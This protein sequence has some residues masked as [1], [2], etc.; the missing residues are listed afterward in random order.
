MEYDIWYYP[1]QLIHTIEIKSEDAAKRAKARAPNRV[2]NDDKVLLG[3]AYI[4][5]DI[6]AALE[7]KNLVEYELENHKRK[8]RKCLQ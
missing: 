6:L 7:R 2:N 1:Y 8:Y 4:I 3:K 5:S